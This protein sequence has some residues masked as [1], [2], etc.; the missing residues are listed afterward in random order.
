MAITQPNQWNLSVSFLENYAEKPKF[1]LPAN[2]NLSQKSC[3]E[4]PAKLSR[5]VALRDRILYFLRLF[6]VNSCPKIT[7]LVGFY[8]NL[9]HHTSKAE[10]SRSHRFFGC[11][12]RQ[13]FRFGKI[14]YRKMYTIFSAVQ[15]QQRKS[16]VMTSFGLTT[17]SAIYYHAGSSLKGLSQFWVQYWTSSFIL[18]DK[19]IVPITCHEISLSVCWPFPKDAPWSLGLD[20]NGLYCPLQISHRC[21]SLRQ[22][23]GYRAPL[24]I[25]KWRFAVILCLNSWNLSQSFNHIK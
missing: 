18:S 3:N 8:Q 15:R 12:Y 23:R 14:A 5:N 6:S 7:C 10:F 20:S 9:Y 4:E 11:R 1:Q 16:D 19:V 2:T 21:F 25:R 13:C 22:Y 24:R 17:C